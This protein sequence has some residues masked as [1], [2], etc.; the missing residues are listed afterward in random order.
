MNNDVRD[1]ANM[2]YGEVG[3]LDKDAMIMVG[4][5]AV[6]RL[7]S[8]KAQ[9]FGGSMRDVLQ[10]G[11]Y[12][13]SNPNIM[14]KQALSG[15]FPDDN[16]ANKYKL[17]ITVASGLMKGGIK[18]T[19]GHFYFTDNEINKLKKNPKA[20]NFRAVKKIGKVNKYTVYGY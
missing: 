7:K 5:T 10:K 18:P 15:K 16:S 19:E 2:I 20:F 12:A 3:S 9:E 8:G 11:Y 13:I 1:L 17:A 6:N 14:T 4:S